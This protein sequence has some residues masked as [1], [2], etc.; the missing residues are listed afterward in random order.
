MPATAAPAYPAPGSSAYPV[1]GSSAYPASGVHDAPPLARTRFRGG[2]ESA[3]V[4]TLT[5]LLLSFGLV[6]LYSASSFLAQQEGLPDYHFVVRQAMGAGAGLV[7]LLIFARIPYGKWQSLAW[8]M[9]LVA[10]LLLVFIILPGTE[11]FAPERNGARRWLQLGPASFQPS[12][13]AKLAILVWTAVLAVR[14]Q[15]RFQS[16]TRGLG[17]FLVVWAAMLVPVLLEPDFSTAVL[18]GMLGCIIVFTAGARP[19]HFVFLGVLA[20]PVVLHQ[21]ATDFREMRIG[22]FLNPEAHTSG[23]GYQVHQSLIAIGSG[24]IG[25]V[26]FGE[27]QQKFG[28]LPEAHNDFIF[29]LIGEEWGLIG[30]ALLVCVY[31]ALILVGFRIARRAADL[32]GELLAIGCTSL[33]ALHAFLHMG[34]NLSLLPA[35]GL[36]LPLISDGRSNLVVTL[37]AIGILLSVARGIPENPRPG[38]A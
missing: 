32:L 23:A 8:P 31:V 1:S 24:G 21:F 19:G 27:G 26:G 14:K 38:H 28:F 7:C 29:A 16:L 17:P 9:M 35:T 34:V 33:I 4:M 15:D 30:V 20:L 2:W 37:A 25:G 36:P 12:E 5:L 11:S 13:A 18:I 6:T 22:A 10:W 3:A